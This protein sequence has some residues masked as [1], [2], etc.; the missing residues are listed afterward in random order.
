MK[1]ENLVHIKLEYDEAVDGKK[2][3]L[4]T[5][6][7]LLK[8]T[9]A[10]KVYYSLKK[11]ESQTKLKLSKKLRS[12]NNFLKKIKTNLPQI[13]VRKEINAHSKKKPK[14]EKI[15]YDRG[16]EDQL[17]DIQ[18]KLNSLQNKSR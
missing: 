7:N 14:R 12:T 9:R 2:D 10:V 13:R 1:N 8:I 3:L 5:Q 16:I 17:L 11:K 15:E 18:D 4:L 6:M